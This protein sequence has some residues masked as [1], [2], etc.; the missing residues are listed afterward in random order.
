MN[1]LKT[2]ASH[3]VRWLDGAGRPQVTGFARLSAGDAC[4]SFGRPVLGWLPPKGGAMRL[5]RLEAVEP[6]PTGA[7][8]AGVLHGVL[9]AA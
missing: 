6:T 5:S 3:A 4:G 7:D 2:K 8:F 9:C 1:W